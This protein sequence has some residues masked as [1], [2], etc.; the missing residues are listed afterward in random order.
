[1]TYCDLLWLT[2]PF[3]FCFV[4]TEIKSFTQSF[5]YSKLIDWLSKWGVLPCHHQELVDL[6]VGEGTLGVPQLLL[7]LGLV[8]VVR[9]PCRTIEERRSPTKSPGKPE[10]FHRRPGVRSPS[11]WMIYGFISALAPPLWEDLS[12]RG[13]LSQSHHNGATCSRQVRTKAGPLTDRFCFTATR[14]TAVALISVETRRPWWCQAAAAERREEMMNVTDPPAA[15][16][17][18]LPGTA[19]PLGSLLCPLAAS[20]VSGRTPASRRMYPEKEVGIE[21]EIFLCHS[22]LWFIYFLRRH[23]CSSRDDSTIKVSRHSAAHSVH[24]ACCQTKTISS[25]RQRDKN[26]N[27]CKKINAKKLNKHRFDE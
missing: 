26:Q 8:P 3:Y 12:D 14:K 16:P 24:S 5:I 13:S 18:R 22:I 11:Y 10:H 9:L 15:S 20:S 4:V 7:Q 6:F 21:M 23:S 19:A 1:M 27:M 25:L 2:F 17:V